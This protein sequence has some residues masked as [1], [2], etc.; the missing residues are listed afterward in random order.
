MEIIFNVLDG[1]ENPAQEP[2]GQ[3]RLQE[4]RPAQGYGGN[5]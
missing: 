3:Q 4:Q 5:S 2:V 1:S